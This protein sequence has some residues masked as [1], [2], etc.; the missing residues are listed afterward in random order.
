MI[1]IGTIVTEHLRLRP[2]TDEDVESVWL[3]HSDSRTN[4]FNPAGPMTDRSQAEEQAREWAAN[5]VNDG[6]GYWALEDLQVPGVVI[7]FGGIRAMNWRGRQVYN[8]YYRL[9]PAAWGRGLASELVA[10][11]VERWHEFGENRPLVA[12]TTADNLPSQRTAVKGGLTRRPDL[13]EVTN[14]YTDVVFA[15]GLD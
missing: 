4:R 9:A 2:V 15:I 14:T 1:A 5:W 8:L 7:G 11:A 13:D 12:Y 3:L 10:A 6:H